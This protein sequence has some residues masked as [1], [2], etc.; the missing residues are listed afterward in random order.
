MS[1]PLFFVVHTCLPFCFFEVRV[2]FMQTTP[3]II[4]LRAL[5]I[6]LVMCAR[7]LVLR[8]LSA[9]LLISVFTPCSFCCMLVVA[10]LL[11]PLKCTSS[12]LHYLRQQL[13]WTPY[14]SLWTPSDR[15]A[16]IHATQQVQYVNHR[17]ANTKRKHKTAL[18]GRWAHSS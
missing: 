6:L 16:T 15:D 14:G 1:S 3:Q 10:F 7:L 17:C 13:L 12:L 2:L 4:L 9:R 11:L 18:T 5:A 8:V